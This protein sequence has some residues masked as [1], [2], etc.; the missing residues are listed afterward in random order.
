MGRLFAE[1]FARLSVVQ[2]LEEVSDRGINDLQEA[3]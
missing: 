2:L 1:P 3:I